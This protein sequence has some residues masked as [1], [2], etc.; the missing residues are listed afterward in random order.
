MTS[1]DITWSDYPQNYSFE[2]L[3]VT[4]THENITVLLPVEVHER[5]YHIDKLIMAYSHY[6]F[7]MYGFLTQ[8]HTDGMYSSETFSITTMEGGTYIF[9]LSCV[10]L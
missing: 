8:E 3:Y 1:A 6:T 2:T 10:Q 5:S 7:A 9:S 4:Y